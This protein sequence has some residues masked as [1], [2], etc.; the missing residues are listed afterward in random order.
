MKNLR[1]MT[2]IV[3][4]ISMAAAISA[5]MCACSG[6]DISDQAQDKLQALDKHVLAVKGG[7]NSNYP[8]VTYGEA[9]DYFFSSPAWKYFSG[10]IEGPDE[11]GDGE[12]DY[13]EENVDVVEFT[14]YCTYQEV[15]VK[16]LIQFK[17]S[18]KGDT[19]EATFLSFNDVPQNLLMLGV[20]IEKAFTTYVEDCGIGVDDSVEA[21]KTGTETV[22]TET[23]KKT[24]HN[25][26]MLY[27]D[28]WYHVSYIGEG[29]AMV[30]EWQL[31]SAGDI[32]MTG[33]LL[34]SSYW[35]N[36]YG[37]YDLK[38]TDAE[39]TWILSYSG[40]LET[41]DDEGEYTDE[42]SGKFRASLNADGTLTLYYESGDLLSEYTKN[43]PFI[44]SHDRTD[45]TASDYR[46]YY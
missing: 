46:D 12:P 28:W 21:V 29:G 10:T 13:V 41:F 15:E 8:D 23:G 9:F 31:G 38:E 30:Y 45:S 17:L 14:G 6:D 32:S 39:N 4:M 19:F 34:S 7:T 11:D 33:T 20:L 44:L 43:N 42:I 2:A 27:D 40:T 25:E 36:L 26:S 18:E 22:K 5:F 3:L 37:L 35:Y 1:K 24:V 16:A